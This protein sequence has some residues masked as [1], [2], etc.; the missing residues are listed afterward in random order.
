MLNYILPTRAEYK[1]TIKYR[2]KLK[3]NG[4]PKLWHAKKS[5]CWM[6][7]IVMM[8][9]TKLLPSIKKKRDLNN[10]VE[11]WA[12]L[13]RANHDGWVVVESSDKTTSTG[14][15]NGK[16]LLNSCLEN[17]INSMKRRKDTTLKDKLPRSVG[18]QYATGRVEK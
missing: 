10:S 1:D 7:G 3:V 18:A 13:C 5:A 6:A 14:E 12:L 15:V 17:P 8:S 16:P 2:H 11:L 4:C 9:R